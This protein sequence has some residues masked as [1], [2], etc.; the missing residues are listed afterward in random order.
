MQSWVPL[1]QA[2]EPAWHVMP[3]LQSLSRAQQP[4]MAVCAQ[5]LLAV[6]QAP[7][8]QGLQSSHSASY[9]QQFAIA[10]CWHVPLTQL[11]VLHAAPGQ[12]LSAQHAA[13]VVPHALVP[14]GQAVQR[15]A[16]PGPLAWQTR[17]AQQVWFP[18]HGWPAPRQAG[19]AAVAPA[20]PNAPASSPT[21]P[22]PSARVMA[23]RETRP[24]ANLFAKLS[25]RSPSMSSPPAHPQ[26]TA[27][28]ARLTSA[29]GAAAWAAR[30]L[31][32]IEVA[33]AGGGGRQATDGAARGSAGRRAQ[34]I[35][36]G[37][38]ALGAG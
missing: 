9:V 6:S 12:S 4:G 3:P 7:L 28:W 5:V 19:C 21:A 11:P 34:D 1:G 16:A 30:H 23:R 35:A 20:R 17:P 37:L 36:R 13:Q 33:R 2:Q 25:K 27:A 10:D 15:S 32:A 29:T 22:P 18:S 8:V 38:A 14:G 26:M 31:T 24:L